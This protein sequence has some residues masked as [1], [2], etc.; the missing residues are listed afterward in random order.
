MKILFSV[1]TEDHDTEE[2][3][4]KYKTTIE[5]D[6]E[7]EEIDSRLQ[8]YD[9]FHSVL[10]V[11]NNLTFWDIYCFFDISSDII[12]R[13]NDIPRTNSPH[14]PA[15]EPKVLCVEEFDPGN[16]DAPC[17]PELSKCFVYKLSRYECGASGFDAIVVWASSHPWLMVFIGGFI[18]DITKCFVLS[19]RKTLRKMLGKKE[20]EYNEQKR[21]QIVYFKVAKFYRNF[22]KMVNV[23]KFDCQ[24]VYLKRIRGGSFEV[25]VRTVA[26]EYYVVKCSCHGKIISLAMNDAQ[27]CE[28]IS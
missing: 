1:Y 18:W 14:F 23:A 5:T 2:R 4:L 3:V 7:I 6:I 16:A 21:K 9:G 15:E 13:I 25:H 27:K 8:L 19:L 20:R 17:Y 10:E 12:E 26:D 28:V 11:G 22:S 24:I